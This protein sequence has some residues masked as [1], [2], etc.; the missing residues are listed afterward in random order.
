MAEETT[1]TEQVGAEEE[2]NSAPGT[3]P[4]QANEENKTPQ[5]AGKVSGVTPTVQPQ[6]G[7][8]RTQLKIVRESIQSLS[9]EVSRF[10][11]SHEASTKKLETH[12]T[13]LRRELATHA[14][15]K[16]LSEHVKSHAV[17]TKR[18]EKQIVTLRSEMNSLKSQM[19]KDA[20]KSRAWEKVALSKIV[21]K[22]KTARKLKKTRT[23]PSKS[24]R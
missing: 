6:A 20:A 13:S 12:L 16:D 17:D 9:D 3:M 10:R 7:G 22:V 11:K 21:S 4:N 2:R 5:A 23:R 18:L 15:S 24:K 1:S 14:R 8:R 19:A